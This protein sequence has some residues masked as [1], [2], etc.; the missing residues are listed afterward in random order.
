MEGVDP[1]A[2]Y[3]HECFYRSYRY[4]TDPVRLSEKTIRLVHGECVL[5]LG[6]HAWVELPDGLVFDGVFQQ[7]Y[8]IEDWETEISGRAWYKF[9]PHAASLIL[10]NMPRADDGQCCY[11]WDAVLNLSRFRGVPLEIDFDMAWDLIVASGIRDE[12]ENHD[13][14]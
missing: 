9:T 10:A 13:Q 2:I 1:H 7:Y 3:P 11:Q 8:R 14:P 5:A 12:P 6:P 4:A